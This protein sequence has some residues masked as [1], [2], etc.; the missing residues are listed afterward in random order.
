MF[1][2]LN[3]VIYNN[4]K[5]DHGIKSVYSLVQQVPCK[6]NGLTVG[7]MGDS[8]T[9]WSNFDVRFGKNTHIE[10]HQFARLKLTKP[11]TESIQKMDS[12]KILL[13]NCMLQIQGPAVV[14]GPQPK[15]HT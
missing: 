8:V 4:N 6:A 1:E 9:V 3:T 12:S 7:P 15:Q 5:Q 10:S 2:Y 13:L 11:Y 14:M